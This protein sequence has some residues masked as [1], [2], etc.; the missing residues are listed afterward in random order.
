[1]KAKLNFAKFLSD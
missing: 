1:M